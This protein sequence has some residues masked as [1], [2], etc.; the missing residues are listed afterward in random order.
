MK[1]KFLYISLFLFSAL[2]FYFF[3]FFNSGCSGKKDWNILVIT[4]DTTRA[5]RLRCYGYQNVET[6]QLNEMA[7]DGILFEHA[8]SHIPLTLPAH[9]SIMTGTLPNYHGIRDNGGYRL[10]DEITTL[11]EVLSDQGYRTAAFIS[12]AVL[13]KIFNLDQGFEHWDEE[14]ISEQK[15]DSPLVA[16]RKGD[17]TTDAM[18]EWLAGQNEDKWFVWLHYYDPHQAYDPPSPYDEL[19][20]RD[21]YAGEIAFTDYQIK[22]VFNY[23][24]D[25][26]LYD[27]TLIIVIGDHGEGLNE[28]DER[29]HATYIY[30]TTQW[31][32]FLIRVPGLKDTGRRI[33]HIVSQIDVMPT[34]LD[35]LS[36]KCPSD[37]QGVSLKD[38]ILD[39][40]A[41]LEA[42]DIYLESRFLLLHF[43]WAEQIGLVNSRYKYIRTPKAELYDLVEDPQEVNNLAEKQPKVLKEM[44]HRLKELEDRYTYEFIESLESDVLEL[45]EKTRKQLAALGYLPG[46]VVIDEEKANRKD[47]KDYKHIFQLYQAANHA[48]FADDYQRMLDLCQR[49]LIEDPENIAGINLKGEALYGLG[50]FEE[51]AEW[52]KESIEIL[53]EHQ[54]AYAKLG[55][56]YVRMNRLADAKKYLEKAIEMNPKDIH[57]IYYLG[58]IYLNFGDKEKAWQT[59]QKEDI[60]NTAFGHLGMAKYYESEARTG[61][62][63]AEYEESLKIN[64]KLAITYLEYAGLLV[65]YKED[66]EKAL[67]YLEKA[68][69]L[70]G[71]QQNDPKYTNYYE[72]AIRRLEGSKKSN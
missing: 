30:N 29:T 44:E 31:V 70:D 71:S 56:I 45:D 14:G 61:R 33:S 2:S 69:D 35:F 42:R 12:A 11:A 1:R 39:E 18:L 15:E 36:V 4:T 49:M 54:G 52:Q 48:F 72:T 53:G 23:L 6:P 60:K 27:K 43:G 47:P 8:Y 51:A 7:R 63:E 50:R 24:K 25:S 66:Y 20:A 9:T 37:V 65:Y 59:F 62:A 68:V 67:E 16:E 5:D 13:K 34:V 19:Y 64:D 17:K 10:R 22:R 38:I 58:R 21:L 32:P 46:Q 41:E 3:I 55:N 28:H 26:G 57:S 40:E